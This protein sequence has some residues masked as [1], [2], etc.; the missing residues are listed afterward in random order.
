MDLG[1]L[2]GSSTGEAGSA[3]EELVKAH[4]FDVTT[5]VSGNPTGTLVFTIDGNGLTSPA[6]QFSLDFAKLDVIA[7][8]VPVL[9][10]M[11]L[12]G[13]GLLGFVGVRRSKQRLLRPPPIE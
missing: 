6:D 9:G 11:L 4:T 13:S 8:P 10:A 12:L 5:L 1:N 3:D 2:L 7:A